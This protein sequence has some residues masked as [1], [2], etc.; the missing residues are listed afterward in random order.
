MN[1]YFIIISVFIIIVGC[2]EE[3]V[4]MSRESRIPIGAVKVSASSDVYPP[5]MH[6][7]DYEI[8]VSLPFNT[9]GAEDSA[10]VVPG[11]IYFFFTP[12]VRIPAEK[13]LF[14][15]VTGIYFFRNNDSGVE[16]IVLQAG[17]KLALD[18]CVFVK[19]DVMW[20]CSA[21]E[22][23]EGVNFFTAGL[24]KGK[25][26]DFEYVGDV[27]MKDY[28]VGEMHIDKSILYFHSS[29]AG[30]KGGLDI[31]QSRN[32]GGKWMPPENIDAVNS[33]ENEGWPFVRNN[34]LWFTRT[35]NGSPAVFRSL[36]VNDSW[37]AP[38][39]LVSQFAG[40]PSVDDFG[41][42]YFTH[43]F[44]QNNSMIEADIYVARRK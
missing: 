13:Q 35:L 3:K 6:S 37:S 5:V 7:S 32:S 30:G 8:P 44:Y 17:N 15:G 27:L 24:M 20:F 33:V 43:H 25:W 23:Y 42:V 2:S 10:F 39:L 38:E 41:N 40:E 31:W 36:L 18:G 19:D 14:D 1:K 21:R 26:Q 11:G 4:I 22:G 29:R 28:E 12:D 34:E 9:A 16:R